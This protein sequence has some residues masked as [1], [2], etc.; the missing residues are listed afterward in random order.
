M[1]LG[2][3]PEVMRNIQYNQNIGYAPNP[4]NRRRNQVP[5][6]LTTNTGPQKKDRK[7]KAAENSSASKGKP[8]HLNISFEG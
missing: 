1:P 6:D 8:T 5:Y 3:D 2:I 7:N 4:A